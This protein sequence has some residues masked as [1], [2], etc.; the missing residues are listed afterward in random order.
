M[1]IRVGAWLTSLLT[2]AWV[3]NALTVPCQAGPLLT[4]RSAVIAE[5]SLPIVFVTDRKA[6]ADAMNVSTNKS[7]VSSDAGDASYDGRTITWSVLG[8]KLST[9]ASATPDS[10]NVPVPLSDRT[11][12]GPSSVTSTDGM[13][14]S[15]LDTPVDGDLDGN[16]VDAH[17]WTVSDVSGTAAAQIDGRGRSHYRSMVID[18]F[19]INHYDNAMRYRSSASENRLGTISELLRIAAEVVE[20]SNVVSSVICGSRGHFP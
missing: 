4:M 20:R 6:Q 11:L 1:E 14:R 9:S 15:S 19:S 5:A 10:S 3:V 17:L 2:L 13:K 7:F 18:T 16:E 8:D 12:A